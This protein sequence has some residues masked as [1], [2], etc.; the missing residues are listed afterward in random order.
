MYAKSDE[1]LTPPKRQQFVYRY[2]LTQ[3]PI[4]PINSIDK[5]KHLVVFIPHRCSTSY[6]FNYHPLSIS[7][8]RS[9][10][11]SGRLHFCQWFFWLRSESKIVLM[12]VLGGNENWKEIT[13]FTIS[14][15]CLIGQD[16]L[17]AVHTNPRITGFEIASVFH[18]GFAFR[19]H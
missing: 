1:R 9:S 3:W 18:S 11:Y 8:Y 12:F 2:L 4:H 10:V 5:T 6:F 16:L 15:L 14:M 7:S 13:L 17:G 19:L